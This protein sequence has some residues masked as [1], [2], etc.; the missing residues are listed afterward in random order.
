MRGRDRQASATLFASAIESGVHQRLIYLARPST[1]RFENTVALEGFAPPTAVEPPPR[2][3]PLPLVTN[4]VQP[5]SDSRA[6]QYDGEALPKRGNHVSP[7]PIV[8]RASKN[9]AGSPETP[10]G[11]PDPA[12]PMTRTSSRLSAPRASTGSVSKLRLGHEA[13][14]D[15]GTWGRPSVQ[16]ALCDDMERSFVSPNS[17]TPRRVTP[18]SWVSLSSIPVPSFAFLG[19]ARVYFGACVLFPLSLFTMIV[20]F[21]DSSLECAV[22]LLL[23]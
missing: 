13:R 22:T 7:S 1:T 4:T 8:H 11:W 21:G 16:A 10:Q 12:A 2:D 17:L 20:Y 5:T 6:D 15:E 14:D 3:P 9:T 23:S 19:Q 18:N